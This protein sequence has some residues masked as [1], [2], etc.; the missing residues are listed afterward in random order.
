MKETVVL[1]H[2]DNI[3]PFRLQEQ[4][5]RP[6]SDAFL[7][8]IEEDGVQQPCIVTTTKPELDGKHEMISGHNRRLGTIV[9][10]REYVPC[11]VREY[12]DAEA[13]ERAFFAGN[14]WNELTPKQKRLLLERLMAMSESQLESTLK[15]SGKGKAGKGVTAS[16]TGSPSAEGKA[17]NKSKKVRQIAAITG[18]SEATIERQ[19]QLLDGGKWESFYGE[20]RKLD[21]TPELIEKA[22]AARSTIVQ[23]FDRGEVQT[24]SLSDEIKAAQQELRTQCPKYKKKSGKSSKESTSQKVTPKEAKKAV[25]LYR[26]AGSGEDFEMEVHLNTDRGYIEG[27]WVRGSDAA[28]PAVSLTDQNGVS[29]V[30]VFTWEN[31]AAHTHQSLASL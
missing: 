16:K 29:Q 6:M 17:S 15:E 21:A 23:R 18:D 7:K 4:F 22:K 28:L 11:I 3:M 9:C 24:R 25:P 2:V 31:L 1:I 12:A 10:D 26:P 20:L 27:G 8:S 30:Y 14:A 13:E 19:L 5:A